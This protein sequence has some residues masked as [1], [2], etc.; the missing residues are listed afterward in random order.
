[1]SVSSVSV[2]RAFLPTGEASQETDGTRILLYEMGRPPHAARRTCILSCS[3][4]SRLELDCQVVSCLLGPVRL[5][6]MIYYQTS[7]K[8]C[9]LGFFYEVEK[10][11]MRWKR[12]VYRIIVDCNTRNKIL[13]MKQLSLETK[14][15]DNLL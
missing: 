13:Y 2:S 6:T 8:K 5:C 3:D 1:M 4:E 7:I 15:K 10:R 14:K 11:R 9:H 12:V